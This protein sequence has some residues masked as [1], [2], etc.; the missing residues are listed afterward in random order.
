MFW[1]YEGRKVSHSALAEMLS[2][3]EYPHGWAM[4][5]LVRQ[6]FKD[7]L[8]QQDLGLEYLWK[9]FTLVAWKNIRMR[10]LIMD[11]SAHGHDFTAEEYYY[12]RYSTTD[13]WIQE[14]IKRIFNSGLFWTVGTAEKKNP[15]CHKYAS[16]EGSFFYVFRGKKK[17]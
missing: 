13:H 1:S 15:N 2:Y 9:Y 16:F 14:S 11:D 3:L 12:P 7:V 10:I 17:T 5:A 8:I 6:L 4:G